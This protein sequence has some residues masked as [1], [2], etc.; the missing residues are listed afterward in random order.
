M[1]K[2]T[3]GTKKIKLITRSS[4]KRRL[5]SRLLA[6]TISADTMKVLRRRAKKRMKRQVRRIAKTLME[7]TKWMILSTLRDKNTKVAM[8]LARA[9]KKREE[10]FRS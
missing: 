6:E 7:Q 4:S 5:L 8:N 2:K 10:E 1:T 9:S 3:S